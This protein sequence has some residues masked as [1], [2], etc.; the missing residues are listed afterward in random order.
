MST[1]Q[2]RMLRY[3]ERA[4]E[5]ALG[6]QSENLKKAAEV[7]A[8]ADCLVIGGAAG[9]SAVDGLD[10]QSEAVLKREFPYLWELGY[11]SLWQAMWDDARWNHA[12]KWCIHAAEIRWCYY[13]MP[14]L[15]A[16]RN[17]LDIVKDKDYFVLSSNI[18]EQFVKAGF[19]RDRIFSP[20]NSMIR[21]QCSVPCCKDIW[22]GRDG[23]YHILE[24]AD[25]EHVGCTDEMLPFCPH[26]GAPAA[27]N[28]RGRASFI[29]DEV[30]ALRPA[31]EKY[32]EDARDKKVVFMEMGA[33]FNT[34]GVIRHGFQRLT[35]LYPNATLIR[36]NRD[37]PIIPEKIRDKGIEIGGDMGEALEK[38][39]TEL[40]AV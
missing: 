19:R 33:G 6:D 34:P 23:Y 25:L 20:Q 10:Y 2:E 12:Q 22:D 30:M 37:Y 35:R 5:L 29:P 18:D 8:G 38:I 16:Y 11:K 4:R 40:G 15:K 9:L 36:F 1:Y 21:F 13:E 3:E 17:L 24:V 26:C 14:V 39:K 32:I 27:W 28:M 7:I 31:F